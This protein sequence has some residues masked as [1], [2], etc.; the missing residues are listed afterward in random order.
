[1]S[2][3]RERYDSLKL[4]VL[5]KVEFSEL[6]WKVLEIGRADPLSMTYRDQL[7]IVVAQFKL[8]AREEV[9]A[10]ARKQ[11]ATD[12]DCDLPVIEKYNAEITAI[13]KALFDLP[14]THSEFDSRIGKFTNV[15]APG[16]HEDFGEG[17]NRRVY[18]S[19]LGNLPVMY[20]RRA[21]MQGTSS[22]TMGRVSELLRKATGHNSSMA[23]IIKSKREL[24]KMNILKAL[25][26]GDIAL[27]AIYSDQRDVITSHSRPGQGTLH[28]SSELP[29]RWGLPRSAYSAFFRSKFYTPRS[30]C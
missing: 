13:D 4:E 17:T 10:W 16:I 29:F 14:Y 8:A 12:W 28:S 15:R 6:E 1:M 25:P 27:M 21:E 18:L 5:D 24:A 22:A 26:L 19:R 7:P 23:E 2:S 30:G 20:I 11:R 9:M 3:M